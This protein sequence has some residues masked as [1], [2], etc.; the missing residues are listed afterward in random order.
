MI[1][2]KNFPKSSGVYFFKDIDNNILYI[3]KAKSLK[4][5]LT[6]YF[7]SS[8]DKVIELLKQ[9]V[10]IEVITTN[11]EIEALFLEA[12]LIKQHQPPFNRLLKEGNPYIYIFF[13]SSE[14]TPTISTTRT[15]KKKG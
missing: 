15:K 8:E 1:N 14:K 11:N 2:S 3:G 10:D 9:A 7:S 12:Q 4:N 5:R 6:S 13:S